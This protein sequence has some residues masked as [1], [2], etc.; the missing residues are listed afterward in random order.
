[1]LTHRFQIVFEQLPEN[2]SVRSLPSTDCVR[3]PGLVPF[4]ELDITANLPSSLHF[5][6]PSAY[7]H[8]LFSLLLSTVSPSLGFSHHFS[9]FK[10]LTSVSLKHFSSREERDREEQDTKSTDRANNPSRACPRGCSPL[11]TQHGSSSRSSCT[12]KV[13]AGC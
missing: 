2:K 12:R 10:A 5:S 1:M 7:G 4:M 13:S 3:K 9:T 6:L 11:A 8:N